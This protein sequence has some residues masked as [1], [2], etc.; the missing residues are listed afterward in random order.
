M[1]GDWKMS[2]RILT[3]N[4]K[5]IDLDRDTDVESLPADSLAMDSHTY[6]A[7]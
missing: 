7:T 2:K 1:L 6:G 4:G 5:V 3:S